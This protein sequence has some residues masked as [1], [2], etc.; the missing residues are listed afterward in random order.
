MNLL[1]LISLLI[2]TQG[3]RG[4]KEELTRAGR[5]EVARLFSSFLF[6]EMDDEEGGREEAEE[7][8]TTETLGALYLSAGTRSRLYA[9]L[10]VRREGGR[11]G[12]RVLIRFGVCL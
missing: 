4:R 6:P 8:G 10:V 2:P 7:G 11:E 1:M 3:S 5:A 12:G 9:L